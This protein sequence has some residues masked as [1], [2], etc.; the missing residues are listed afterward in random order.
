M[1]GLIAGLDKLVT[2]VQTEAADAKKDNSSPRTN[3]LTVV[4]REK[5]HQTMLVRSVQ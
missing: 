3:V 4:K 1:D 2:S 5:V